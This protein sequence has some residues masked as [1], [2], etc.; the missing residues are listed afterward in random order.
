MA[1]VRTASRKCP[2]F[3]NSSIFKLELN[4]TL[5]FVAVGI[6][7]SLI[8]KDVSISNK[9]SIIEGADTLCLLG[10]YI[11]SWLI[12]SNSKRR[13]GTFKKGKEGSSYTVRWR[14]PA[15]T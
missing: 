7:L 5:Q 9:V 8:P 6:F 3:A 11:G 14:E 2:F 13:E 12:L 4:Q 15:T 10:S 1:G